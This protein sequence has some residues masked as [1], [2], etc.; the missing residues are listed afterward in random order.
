MKMLSAKEAIAFVN[1]HA[2]IYGQVHTDEAGTKR[3]FIMS[4]EVDRAGRVLSVSDIIQA[5]DGGTFSLESIRDVLG[6]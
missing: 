6:Y 5:R 3:L 4:E 2:P 1:S